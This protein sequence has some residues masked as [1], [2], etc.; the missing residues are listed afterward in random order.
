MQTN[1][2]VP[3]LVLDTYTHLRL[4]VQEVPAILREKARI[5]IDLD[6]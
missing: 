2:V 4:G 3:H 5:K 6:T 1:L